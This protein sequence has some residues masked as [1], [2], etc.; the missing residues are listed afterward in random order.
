MIS[1]WWGRGGGWSLSDRWAGLLNHMTYYY[2]IPDKQGG[3]ASW[4]RM[5]F[6][7]CPSVSRMVKNSTALT[8]TLCVCVCVCVWSFSLQPTCIFPSS[9]LRHLKLWEEYFLRYDN[10]QAE[11]QTYRREST[12]TK[13]KLNSH[14]SV[15]NGSVS[16]CVCVYA[17]V[18]MCVICFNHGV[19]QRTVSSNSDYLQDSWTTDH[20]I[21]TADEKIK[22][23]MFCH[24]KFSPFRRK[25]GWA[26]PQQ[27][28]W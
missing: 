27:S 19:L 2:L 13:V 7:C 16:G 6:I 21:W 1:L 14:Q 18:C 5:I 26:W 25:V 24:A 9:N 23:C 15:R 12:E 17:Y 28:S 10:S 3:R 20:V 8:R 11:N 22:E 4:Y